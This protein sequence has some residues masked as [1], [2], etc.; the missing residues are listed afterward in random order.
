MFKKL[1]SRLFGKGQQRI[2]AE[3]AYEEE[4][5]R[6]APRSF[7]TCYLRKMVAQQR[8]PMAVRRSGTARRINSGFGM[9]AALHDSRQALNHPMHPLN[10]ASPTYLATHQPYQATHQPVT[11]SHR[12][13]SSCDDS[14]SSDSGS[15]DSGSGGSCD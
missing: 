14:S 3:E 2:E 4:F 7:S 15:S 6:P 9:R 12:S 1:L 5:G 13:H 11:S 8:E 10:Q